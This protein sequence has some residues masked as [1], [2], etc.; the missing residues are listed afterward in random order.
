[1]DNTTGTVYAWGDDTCGGDN[2]GKC[3]TNLQNSAAVTVGSGPIYPRIS[4]TTPEN[5]THLGDNS[6]S[7]PI[8]MPSVVPTSPFQVQ[9]KRNCRKDSCKK[10]N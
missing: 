5:T 1:M 10:R 7:T 6:T 2:Y 4:D 8:A 3:D 9:S